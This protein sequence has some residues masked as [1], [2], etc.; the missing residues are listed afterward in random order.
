MIHP[1]K[2]R[3]VQQISARNASTVRASEK[4]QLSVSI[5]GRQD[6]ACRL[7]LSP[8]LRHKYFEPPCMNTVAQNKI[9]HQT[10][11]NIS[12]ISGLILKIL[13]AA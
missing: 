3:R 10:T 6:E 2:K 5:L 4:V 12:A 1:F 8:W 7:I 13:E 11:C 9:F